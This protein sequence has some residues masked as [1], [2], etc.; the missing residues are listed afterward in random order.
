MSIYHLSLS[1]SLHI[2]LDEMMAG[3]DADFF[4][5]LAANRARRAEV[6][7]HECCNVLLPL[8][9]IIKW[10]MLCHNI[11]THSLARLRSFF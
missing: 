11:L 10:S 9:N 8:C 5:L 6:W 7:N 4:S 1:L 2:I 3:D